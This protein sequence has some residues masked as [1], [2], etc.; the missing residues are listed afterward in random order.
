MGKR[1]TFPGILLLDP[2][3]DG[4]LTPFILPVIKFW[5]DQKVDPL[6]FGYAAGAEAFLTILLYK[7]LDNYQER[8]RRLL[9][10]KNYIAHI[11]YGFV[12][13]ATL[14]AYVPALLYMNI[15]AD[16]Y[17]MMAVVTGSFYY[18]C[19]RNYLAYIKRRIFSPE[20]RE[21]FDRKADK[22]NRLSSIAAIGA[23][24]VYSLEPAD[25]DPVTALIVCFVLSDIGLFAGF[26]YF[27][28]TVEGA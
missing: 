8:Q 6:L 14:S 20:E 10:K 2:F 25:M 24:L 4:L 23:L 18:F 27:Y 3:L 21:L 22:I 9:R 13:L 1:T 17:F 26:T 5:V 16:G 12:A 15:G 11:P 28:C 7:I 19:T